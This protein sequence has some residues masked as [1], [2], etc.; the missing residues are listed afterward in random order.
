MDRFTLGVQWPNV[1]IGVELQS[2]L[3][4]CP[5]SGDE[6]QMRVHSF[7]NILKILKLSIRK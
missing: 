1:A 3:A 2:I 4:F 6:F 5:V 7:V